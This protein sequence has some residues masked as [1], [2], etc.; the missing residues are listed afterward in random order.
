IGD[1]AGLPA[2]GGDLRVKA[3]GHPVEIAIARGSTA[4]RVA[5][6]LSRVLEKLH[7]KVTISPNARIAP[8]ASGS[9]DVLVRRRDGQFA[10]LEPVAAK[11]P[12]SS[13]ATLAARIGSVDLS[14]GLQHFG[15]MD[16]VAGTL[17]ERT[18]LKSIDDGDPHTIEVV[19]VPSF[20]G[21]G[22]IGE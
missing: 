18:L 17:E 10:T 14:D 7:F 13:D 8:G 19:V 3:D 16:S 1:D 12:V 9:V 21:G 2:T 4:D 6:E 20:S 15:D 5:A 11:T 22:R